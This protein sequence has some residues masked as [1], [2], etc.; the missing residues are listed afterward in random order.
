[1]NLRPPP[2]FIP[3]KGPP[4]RPARQ[5]ALAELRGIDL[6]PLEQIRERPARPLGALM[7][8]L[9]Q[10]LRMDQR[11]GEAEIARV[12]NHLLDPAITA[13][14]QPTGINKGTLFV[15]VDSSPWLDEI[16]RYRRKDILTQFL[17]ESLFLGVAGGLVGVVFGLVVAWGVGAW[18]QWQTA[19][20]GTALVAGVGSALLVGVL[21]S[22]H[23]FCQEMVITISKGRWT[24]VF[25]LNSVFSGVIIGTFRMSRDIIFTQNTIDMPN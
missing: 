6:A 16:V 9:V 1:M 10:R 20:N 4:R 23:C 13:H 2:R 7:P 22:C 12:W 11:Q 24:Q 17:V 21:I 3:A 15:T 8:A 19:V 18:T 14:A 5:R 25:P